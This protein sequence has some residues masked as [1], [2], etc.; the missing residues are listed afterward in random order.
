LKSLFRIYVD[1]VG[2]HDL[3][4]ADDPNE[5]FL[6]LTGVIFESDYIRETVIPELNDLKLK[7]FETDPDE[8]VI[9][10]R[11]DIIKKR[12][13]FRILRDEEKRK[14]FDERILEVLSRW[15]YHVV[16]VVIDKLAHREQYRVWTYHPYHYCLKVL[17]ERFFFFL[18]DQQGRGDVMVESRGGKEDL[19]LKKSYVRLYRTGTDYIKAEDLR[20][21]LT[22][23]ELKV[24][25]KAANV[26]GLQ[27][28]DVIAYPARREILHEKGLI[29]PDRSTFSDRITEIIVGSKYLRNLDTGD[30]WGYGKK[31]LP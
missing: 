26:A 4:S 11:K 15:D 18:K 1:E 6:S 30:I 16:T 10:H 21:R 24:K 28:A 2:N 19:Q 3:K 29:E 22:S 27:V 13:P 20:S 23:K 17:L 9:L 7:I 25:L 31:F 12:G 5:R 8:P 14:A